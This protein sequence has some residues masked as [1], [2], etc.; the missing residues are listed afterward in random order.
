MPTASTWTLIFRHLQFP[1]HVP[2]T[3][4][5]LGD[6]SGKLVTIDNYQQLLRPAQ[7]KEIEG[8]RLLLTPFARQRFSQTEDR[9]AS[10]SAAV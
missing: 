3:R 10:T 4:P 5:D 6:V 2:D 9:A 1:P 8:L 7:L